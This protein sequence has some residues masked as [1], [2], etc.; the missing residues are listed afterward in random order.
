[1]KLK[2]FL[3][4]RYQVDSARKVAPVA[5]SAIGMTVVRPQAWPVF[6]LAWDQGVAHEAVSANTTGMAQPLFATCVPHATGKIAHQ[7]DHN[8]GSWQHRHQCS[9]CTRR[10]G[11][12]VSVGSS[13]WVLPRTRAIAGASSGAGSTKVGHGRAAHSGTA[14]GQFI[15]GVIS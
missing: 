4:S 3:V 8:A 6:W 9:S 15:A 10:A 13:A 1:M 11:N 5:A 7:R 2:S 12:L 14:P